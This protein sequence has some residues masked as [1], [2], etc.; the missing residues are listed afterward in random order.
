MRAVG[1]CAKKRAQNRGSYEKTVGQRGVGAVTLA[2]IYRLFTA[3]I[4]RPEE[5]YFLPRRIDPEELIMVF[6]HIEKLKSALT[7]K[8]VVV[9]ESRPELK[10][11]TGMTGTVKTVN[12]SGRA[13]VQFD[14]H[15]NIG[16]F[17]IDPTFLRVIDAPL[18][19]PVVEKGA[20]AAK[21]A[22]E[23]PAA[24]PAAAKAE[25]KPAAKPAGAKMSMEE[26]LAAARANKGGG[27]A[28]AAKAEAKPAEAKPA[29]A[30]KPAA[31]PAGKMSMEEMLAAAR[32][33]KP[34]AGGTAPPVKA[35]AP[36]AKAEAPAAAK[37]AAAPAKPAGAMS[38]AEILAAARTNKSGGGEAAPK[39]EKPAAPVKE[40]APPVEQPKVEKA[41]VEQPKPEPP[42]AVIEKP[43][44]A[45]PAGGKVDRA[46]L[47]K[48][49]AG[50]VAYCRKVDGPK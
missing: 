27:A 30:A 47:P 43:V 42:A 4:E 1:T 35:E 12:F 13:L 36:P 11:F 16:W 19:K 15:N 17:D 22:A 10:R 2:L 29:E 48:D 49:V 21:P 28:P 8:Y 18:P 44:A 45:P 14:A 33:N 3:T 23:K 25:E 40:S 26:M 9:D 6:E 34:T 38:V 5:F 46:S 39:A 50:I 20:K 24:K 37:P 41:P 31:K 7:D 32:A